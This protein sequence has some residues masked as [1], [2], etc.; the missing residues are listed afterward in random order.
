M[1]YVGKRN[2]P[3]DA[4]Q[5]VS[6]DTA[7]CVEAVP[8][9]VLPNAGDVLSGFGVKLKTLIVAVVQTDGLLH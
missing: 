1:A 2:H 5:D 4:I 6:A 7:C 9:N 8:R 3:T